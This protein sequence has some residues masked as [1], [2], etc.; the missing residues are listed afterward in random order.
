MRGGTRM[1]YVAGARMRRLLAA[2]HAR[3]AQ[4]RQLLGTSDDELAAGISAKLEQLKD[5]Q[6]AV[7][8]L[9]EELAVEAARTLAAGSEKVAAAHWTARDLPFLQ[10]VAREFARLAP[11][12][13]VLLTAGRGRP[14]CVPALRRGGGDGGSAR[15]RPRGG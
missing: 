5:A 15:R 6:R 3:A 7:R 13:V 8:A 9:E 12:R 14:G 4:L 1:Y 11:D 10:R 2:H